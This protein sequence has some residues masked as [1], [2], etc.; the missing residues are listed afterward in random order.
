MGA[1]VIVGLIALLIVGLE[2]YSWSDYEK[3]GEGFITLPILKL[4]SSKAHG[5]KD[6][7]NQLNPIMLVTIR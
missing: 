1:S 3:W 4:L 7:E 6:F 5:C 2:S